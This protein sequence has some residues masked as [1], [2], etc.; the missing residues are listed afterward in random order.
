MGMIKGMA[1]IPGLSPRVREVAIL[2]VGAHTK[3]AYEVYA[4]QQLSGLPPDDFDSIDQGKCPP[5][6]DEEQR[7]VLK[8]ANGLF[9]AGPLSAEIWEEGT[10]V[11]GIS[12]ATAVVQYVAFY[13][14]IATI[15][16]GFDVQVPK[17]S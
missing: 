7:V 14:Y 15:L 8:M 6:F 17:E 13:K 3:A 4:H 2:V 1:K 5:S 9:A 16:N 11:L 10:K 12:G